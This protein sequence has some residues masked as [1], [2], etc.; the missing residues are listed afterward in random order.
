MFV[1][2]DHDF[3]VVRKFD[4]LNARVLLT[5]QDHLSVFE[6]RLNALVGCYS[7]KKAEDVNNDSISGSGSTLMEICSE[8]YNIL[9]S[10]S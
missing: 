6:E 9:F 10:S 8:D 5:M 1:T 3:F 7:A 2:S 4:K